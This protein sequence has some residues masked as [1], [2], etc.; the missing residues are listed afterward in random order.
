M[1]F[2]YNALSRTTLP[3]DGITIEVTEETFLSE[4][5]RARELLLDI[6]RHGL[7]TSIDDYGTG[8]SSLAYLRD[9]PLS[10]LKMDRSFVASV[11][12][13]PR[14][15]LIV[16][17]TVNMAHA[18]DVHVVAEGVE[19]AEVAEAVTALGVDILQGYYIAPP[20]PADDIE[21]WALQWSRPLPPVM[22][23]VPRVQDRPDSA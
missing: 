1:P 17:S 14:S 19:S 9:L 23:I 12:S 22:H 10:E 6:R 20:M 11:H 4:P 7:R 8:F 18:L 5:E 3:R 2:I 16:E 21:E 13:D 15:R